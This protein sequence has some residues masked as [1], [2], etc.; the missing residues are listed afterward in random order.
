MTLHIIKS[1]QASAIQQIERI[2]QDDDQVLL[3][4][5]GCYLYTLAKKS[6]DK[7]AA[8][9]DHMKMRG[10]VAKADALG[11]EMLSFKEW[12]LLTRSHP[13]STTW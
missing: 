11:V 4:E 8:L 10:L 5:D 3:I 1:G 13:Q 9:S 12:A 6:F 7:V 2:Y